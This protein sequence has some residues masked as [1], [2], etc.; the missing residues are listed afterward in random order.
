MSGA[1]KT[2]WLWSG[3]E[4]HEILNSRKSA[5]LKYIDAVV[6]GPYIEELRCIDD[7]DYKFRGSKNQKIYASPFA[8]ENIQLQF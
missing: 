5:I 4:M 2:I 3:Y 7:P 6:A 8:Q 1:D